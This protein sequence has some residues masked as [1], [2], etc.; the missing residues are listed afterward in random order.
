MKSYTDNVRLSQ[1]QQQQQHMFNHHSNKIQHLFNQ[2][3][4]KDLGE[5]K[6]QFSQHFVHRPTKLINFVTE[7][8]LERNRILQMSN[9]GER[10]RSRSLDHT[11]L[12]ARGHP[13]KLTSGAAGDH[14][15]TLDYTMLTTAGD[16]RGTLDYATL[17][18]GDHRG[19]SA[20]RTLLRANSEGGGNEM[21]KLSLGLERLSEEMASDASNAMKQLEEVQQ[22]FNVQLLTQLNHVKDLVDQRQLKKAVKVLTSA[23]SDIKKRNELVRLVDQNR[24]NGGNGMLNFTQSGSDCLDK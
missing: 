5:A 22:E 4:V 24:V 23:I 15:G 20:N 8:L 2:R 12:A 9:C 7:L 10:T 3:L 11:A 19:T 1:Q 13:R 18:T 14:A 16:H 6:H 21:Q 17:A